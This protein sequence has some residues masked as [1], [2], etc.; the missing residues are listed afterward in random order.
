M[1]VE[2]LVN[3]ILG[4]DELDSEVEPARLLLEE[5]GSLS[6]IKFDK[7]IKLVSTNVLG[8]KVL[9]YGYTKLNLNLHQDPEN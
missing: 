6:L 5:D 7:D 4:K 1:T 8:F 9:A 3:F 2:E